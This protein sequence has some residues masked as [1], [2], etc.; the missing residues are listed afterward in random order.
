MSK[1]IWLRLADVRQIIALIGECRDFGDDARRWRSHLVAGLARLTGAGMGISAEMGD[2]VRGP[3]RDL[4]TATWG[5][6]NGFDQ[7]V[8]FRML[9]EFQ[10]NPLYNPIMNEYIARLPQADGVC[11]ARTDLIRDRDWYRSDY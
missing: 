9:A 4:G 7:A 10:R 1:S 2:C 8:W 3:R 6:E 11:L 5:W